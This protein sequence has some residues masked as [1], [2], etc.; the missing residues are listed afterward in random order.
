[1]TLKVKKIKRVIATESR[2]VCD[3]DDVTGVKK[4]LFLINKGKD[5]MDEIFSQCNL[6]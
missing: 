6:T 5:A 1:V 2:L 3:D 4:T